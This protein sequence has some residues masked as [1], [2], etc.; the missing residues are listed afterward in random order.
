MS[1]LSK[2]DIYKIPNYEKEF[3]Y[4]AAKIRQD[5]MDSVYRSLIKFYFTCT[6]C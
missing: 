4:N 3:Y 6:T 1:F 2:T 5:K